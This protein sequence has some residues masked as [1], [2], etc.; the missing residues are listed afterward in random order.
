MLLRLYR[1]RPGPAVVCYASIPIDPT[2]LLVSPLSNLP[3]LQPGIPHSFLRSCLPLIRS[4]QALQ[5]RS[6]QHCFPMLYGGHHEPG[7]A[8][9][10]PGKLSL[11]STPIQIY[12]QNFNNINH[13]TKK[14]REVVQ[15]RKRSYGPL[16]KDYG[17]RPTKIGLKARKTRRFSAGRND[18]PESTFT[19]EEAKSSGMSQRVKLI[20]FS[21]G[22]TTLT[23]RNDPK[24]DPWGGFDQRRAV[25]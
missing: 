22:F 16:L 24:Q 7:T 23:H 11:L 6:V 19:V 21:F 2:Q 8:E 12:V 9:I 14:V 1:R 10:A 25:H 15:Q 4:L 13:L 17:F 18:I 3:N 5:L 20:K